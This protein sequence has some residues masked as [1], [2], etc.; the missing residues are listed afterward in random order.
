MLCYK[1]CSL[2]SSGPSTC[3]CCSRTAECLDSCVTSVFSLVIKWCIFNYNYLQHF[4]EPG[5]FFVVMI[6]L[7]SDRY[8]AAMSVTCCIYNTVTMQSFNND[9]DT[10]AAC[11]THSKQNYTSVVSLN[12]S[13]CNLNIKMKD[14]HTESVTRTH[15]I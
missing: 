11:V 4:K 6:P 2:C 3:T 15:T 9:H 8:T 1:M 13:N 5:I 12:T 10:N 14:V 7:S